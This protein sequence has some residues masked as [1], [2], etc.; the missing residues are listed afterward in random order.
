ME[1]LQSPLLLRFAPPL[2]SFSFPEADVFAK[3][4]PPRFPLFS[5]S[6]PP[7]PVLRLMVH[8]SFCEYTK[9]EKKSNKT[10]NSSDTAKFSFVIG[11]ITLLLGTKPALSFPSLFG[12]RDVF[13]ET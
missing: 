2:P 6:P 5:V 10:K 4:S 11:K 9:G 8:L 12:L 1:V 7:F 13:F 3:L